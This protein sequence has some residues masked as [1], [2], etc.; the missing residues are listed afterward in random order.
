MLP[1]HSHVLKRRIKNI[2]NRVLFVKIVNG[3]DSLTIYAKNLHHIDFVSENFQDQKSLRMQA[4]LLKQSMKCW[5]TNYL[6]F[7][8][9]YTAIQLINYF[10]FRYFVRLWYFVDLA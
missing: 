3:F 9:V 6:P 2:Y 8:E 1:C 10:L 7:M 4:K 5:L